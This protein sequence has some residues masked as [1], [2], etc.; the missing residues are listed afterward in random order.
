LTTAVLSKDEVRENID[1]LARIV[2]IEDQAA[3]SAKP[4]SPVLGLHCLVPFD[5]WQG[6]KTRCQWAARW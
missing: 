4:R 5:H 2:E 1:A 3:W 6:T